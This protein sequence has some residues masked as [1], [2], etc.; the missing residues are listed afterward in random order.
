MAVIIVCVFSAL[1]WL[2]AV[3]ETREA[4]A[5]SQVLDDIARTNQHDAVDCL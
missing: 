2:T 3:T 1:A 5:P 4:S